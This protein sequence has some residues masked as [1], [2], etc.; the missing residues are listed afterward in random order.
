MEKNLNKTE[1]FV[2]V[3]NLQDVAS[4]DK[5]MIK[6]IIKLAQAT[7]S[8]SKWTIHSV[9]NTNIIS[10]YFPKKSK[11]AF[12][13]LDLKNIYTISPYMVRDVYVDFG[14]EEFVTINV[15]V[16]KLSSERKIIVESIQVIKTTIEEV[17]KKRRLV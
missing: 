4:E 17:S 13:F 16:Y 8:P 7:F 10:F 3:D 2:N 15:P 14:D 12:S 6:T 9:E 11:P 5:E 1:V